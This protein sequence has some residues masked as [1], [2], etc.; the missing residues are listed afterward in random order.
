MSKATS[1]PALSVVIIGRNEGERLVR[2]IES[3]NAMRF[4]AGE[5]EMVYVDSDSTDGSAEKAAA[6]GAKVIVVHPDRPSAAIGRNTG[7]KMATA[8]IVMF[9]DGDCVLHPDFAAQAAQSFANPK[10]AAV[11]GNL[12]ELRPEA[13]VFNRVLDLDWISQPGPSEFCGGNA[14]IRRAAIEQVNGF[15]ETLIAG[16]EPEMC[17]RM[18]ACGY[19]ILHLDLPMAGH[20]LAMTRASQYLRRAFRTGHAYAEVAARFWGTEIPLWEREVRR[21]LIHA[22]F[23]LMLFSA[24]IIASVVTLSPMPF[25]L[26]I[27]VFLLL[28]LRTAIR[29]GWKSDDPVTRLL[30]G[31]HSHLQQIPILCGQLSYWLNRWTGRRQRLIEYKE[32]AR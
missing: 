27:G 24:G 21:T 29:Y 23:L 18:R 9:L 12:R 5:I 31:I 7:W 32:T 26:A 2:C 4:S 17:C 15:D 20:D 22:G 30:Y 3:V 1:T 14:L 8:P 11:F 19:E 10:L 6:L 16:E 13:S 25:L 28:A